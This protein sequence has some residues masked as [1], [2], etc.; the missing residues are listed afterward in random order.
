MRVLTAAPERFAIAKRFNS[1]YNSAIRNDC[2]DMELT[3]RLVLGGLT[4]T[5]LAAAARSTGAAQFSPDLSRLTPEQ[6]AK[7][8]ATHARMMA[9]LTFER[10]TV[11]GARAL[12]EW[13]KL[14]EAG[15]G[16]PVVIGGDEDLE[17][18]ADQFSMGDPAVAGAALPGISARSPA[19]ILAAS[20]DIRFPK[21]LHKWPGAYQPEDLRAPLGEWPTK[22]DDGEPGLTVAFDLLSRQPRD[23]VHILLLPTKNSWEAPA[24][25]RWGDWNACP[26][27]E[28]HVAALR[29]WHQ[30]FG[31]DLIGIN[32]DAMNVRVRNRPGDRGQALALA[33]D[34]YGYCP[35]IVDQGV[36]TIN[37][38]AAE[39]MASDWWY[40]WWD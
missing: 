21:D 16:W 18:I 26:P 2:G 33:H 11:P 29:D 7:Y 12:A 23:K 5:G 36:G 3:R 37:A 9:A 1:S 17:R 30:R 14:K 39:L 25:L 28:Y 6:R 19:E 35:D 10:V 34:L 20:A 40:L 38:L 13:E 32:G 31:A 8:D 27:P 22:V 15:R 24:Y 4:A